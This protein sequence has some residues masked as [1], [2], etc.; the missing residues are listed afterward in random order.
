M[1]A[2]LFFKEKKILED[3][4]ILELVLWELPQKTKDRPHGY[5]YRLY[6][7]DREGKCLIR[8]DNESGKGDHKHIGEEEIV[9]E[10][11]DR[12]KLIKDFYNDVIQARKNKEV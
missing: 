4:Y 7:G 6:F 3:G 8:Y 1:K 11:V 12:N 9:Y 5:K 10:F 2:R